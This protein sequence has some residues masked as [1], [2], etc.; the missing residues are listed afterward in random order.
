[1]IDGLYISDEALIWLIDESDIEPDFQAPFKEAM[2]GAVIAYFL[3]KNAPF[4]KKSDVKKRTKVLSEKAQQLVRALDEFEKALNDF[5]RELRHPASILKDKSIRLYRYQRSPVKLK[6]CR[7]IVKDDTEVWSDAA[8]RA[9][10]DY[11]NSGNLPGGGGDHLF[12]RLLNSLITVYAAGGKEVK[13]PKVDS[14][15]EDDDEKYSGPLYQFMCN[16]F[17]LFNEEKIG[18]K[19][20]LF[21]KAI[22]NACKRWKDSKSV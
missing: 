20:G 19:G 14:Y 5:P 12:N 16:C 6:A 7:K 21:G 3:A 22:E 13:S 9:C 8:S 2:R 18:P 17:D 1:M 4:V 15:A 10:D 11:I